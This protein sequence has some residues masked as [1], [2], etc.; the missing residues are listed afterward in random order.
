MNKNTEKLDSLNLSTGKKAR[1]YNLMY[2]HGPGN[3]MIQILPIDQGLEHG[4]RDFFV[5]PDSKD[6][7]FQLK[8]ALDAN[9]S[10]IALQF[11]IAEKYLDKFAGKVPL[12]LKLNGK[13][14]VPPDDEAFSPLIS[15]VEDAVWLGASAVGYTLYV[16]SPSQDKDF[17]QFSGVRKDAE[18][19][20]MPVIVWAYP[21]GREID[22]KGGKNS[23]YAIDYASRVAQELGADVIK[24]NIAKS[25]KATLNKC[26]EPYKSLEITELEGMKQVV[27]SAGKS[28]VIISGGDM[29]ND[30]MLIE[31]TK[32]CLKAGASGIIYGRN[33]WQRKYEDALSIS[34]KLGKL[35][36]EH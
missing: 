31:K 11:G 32:T 18:K 22:K 16:G 14:E 8:L 1:L 3:G 2:E 21:R 30:D 34:K 4:P 12:I 15:D 20:G 29:I 23:L 19:L 10:G 24:L 25:D 17:C 36:Q 6:P 5:N 33:I 27:R 28:L 13:T 35:L 7:E 9:F 26:P